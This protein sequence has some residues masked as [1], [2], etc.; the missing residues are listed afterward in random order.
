MTLDFPT[1]SIVLFFISIVQVLIMLFVFRIMKYYPG[2]N[3]L[4][5][6][7]MFSS[8]CGLLYALHCSDTGG[9]TWNFLSNL[10]FYLSIIGLNIGFSKFLN[11]TV[12]KWKLLALTSLF[13][14]GLFWFTFVVDNFNYRVV[15]VSFLSAF[16]A[17]QNAEVL[18]NHN[19]YSVRSA[20]RL[21][22]AANLFY[23]TFLIIRGLFTFYQELT[24][25]KIGSFFHILIYFISVAGILL[26]TYC[27]IIMTVQREQSDRK[28]AEERFRLIFK[29]I[30]DTVFISELDT[31]KIIDVNETYTQATGYT[32]EESIGKTTLDLKFWK[33]EKERDHFYQII[34]ENGICKNL[35][36]HIIT[37]NGKEATSLISS[38]IAKWENSTYIIS[39]LRDI[40]HSKE[41]KNKLKKS[42][43]TFKAV[44]EQSPLSFVLTNTS[45]KIE[46]V[47]P[48]FLELMGYEK[49]EVLGKNPRILKSGYHDR[50]F[51]QNLWNAILS[52]N[53]WSS[54]IRNRKKSG[55]LIW[56]K[57]IL[58]PI[59]NEEG[60]IV[61]FL[62]ILE[63]IS[64]RKQKEQELKMLARTDMLTG[65]MNRRSFMEVA[66][67]RLS[68][69]K[70]QGKKAAF[71]MIDIDRFKSIND[72]FGHTMGDRAIRMVTTECQRFIKEFDLLGRIGGE[73]FAA[74][75]IGLYETEFVQTAEMLCR[76]IEQIEL[77][78]E[79]QVE[80]SLRIS[81]GVA[82]F[83]LEDDTLESLM[84]RSD[85]ALYQAK[86]SGRNRISVIT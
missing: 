40:T 2:M 17:F 9:V 74:L 60:E 83:H 10:S 56:E 57:I 41:L 39:V 16:V 64:D 26:W 19:I 29:T 86:N 23:G 31:G 15:V 35:E 44:M 84:E 1:L 58:T 70:D 54:E 34:H 49:H 24:N 79:N 48:K 75:I 65:I 52:G 43:D 46:Y 80:I 28:L 82:F 68:E 77:Y 6:S 62:S 22:A 66:E 14:A 13:F 85:T 71:L 21:V 67:K 73:E 55:E 51:Y 8:V 72:T 3:Y 36:I 27:F 45:G 50:V 30:P 5:S 42:E 69:I 7:C 20:T 63:D 78:S 59:F 37:K 38:S 25:Y 33:N 47:N 53:Q 18:C 12:S 11:L 76:R 32:K 4:L 61:Q 81:V